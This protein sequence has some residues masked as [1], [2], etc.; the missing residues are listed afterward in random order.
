MMS[1]QEIIDL[2]EK[3]IAKNAELRSENEKLWQKIKELEKKI[4][5]LEKN[6][7]PDHD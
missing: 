3:E 6:N 7:E 1:N 2:L 5:N 4:R